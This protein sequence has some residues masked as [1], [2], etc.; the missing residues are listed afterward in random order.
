MRS[1]ALVSILLF[2]TAAFCDDTDLLA[3]FAGTFNGSLFSGSDMD[4]VITSFTLNKQGELSGKYAMGEEEGLEVGTL[5][6]IHIESA[7]S[8]S[9]TW[10]DKYGEGTLRILFS[11]DYQVF[12]G[13]WG[14]SET[15]AA[16]TWNGIRK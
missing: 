14:D 8:I 6:D 15:P 11:E 2:S 16:L 1:I 10:K 12:W 13:F 4:P 9:M 5:K 3:K 7:F